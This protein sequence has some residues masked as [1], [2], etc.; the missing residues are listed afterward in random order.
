MYLFL[1]L[2]SHHQSDQLDCLDHI[3]SLM[4]PDQAR[5]N[6]YLMT[7]TLPQDDPTQFFT[8]SSQQKHDRHHNFCLN[9]PDI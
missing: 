1:M 6:A 9:H 4:K 3:N 8:I 2:C 5:L 7:P